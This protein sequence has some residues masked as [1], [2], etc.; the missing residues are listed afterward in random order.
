MSPSILHPSAARRVAVAIARGK[1]S[2]LLLE[3]KALESATP[4][5]H[6]MGKMLAGKHPEPARQR[7][8]VQTSSVT[9]KPVSEK[10]KTCLLGKAFPNRVD[11]VQPERSQLLQRSRREKRGERKE[12]SRRRKLFFLQHRTARRPRAQLYATTAW[13]FRA[14][15]TARA[16]SGF[17]GKSF[18]IWRLK[19][20]RRALSSGSSGVT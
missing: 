10:G 3:A 1:V 19:Q 8:R 20:A 12:S 5:R 4:Q 18:S 7:E 11:S 17:G 13:I 14:T 16:G 2:A 15:E 9:L 6:H